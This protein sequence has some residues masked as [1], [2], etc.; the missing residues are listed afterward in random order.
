MGHRRYLV[1]RDPAKD[2]LI[3]NYRMDLIQ[4][5]EVLDQSF[6]QAEGFSMAEYAAQSFGIWQDPDQF[7]E[8]VWKFS[9]EAATRAAEFRF[10]P[11]QRLEPQPDGSLTV[12]FE[13]AGWLEMTWHLY[14]WGDK[15]EVLAPEGLRAMVHD[16]RRSDFSS[17]P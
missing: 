13:A 9:P 2:D 3:R 7:G 4:S 15:V 17:M 10:H 16:H 1:A 14:Q 5:A 6:A 12:R 8:V 11:T